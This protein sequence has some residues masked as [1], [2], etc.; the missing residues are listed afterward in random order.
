MKKT[1]SLLLAGVLTF[2][3]LP[4]VNVRAVENSDAQT[5]ADTITQTYG[6]TSVQY[7]LI[8]N[9]EIIESGVSGVYSKYEN[10]LLTNENMYTIGSTSKMF[11]TASIMKLVQEGKIDLDR[12]VVRYVPQFKMKDKRYRDITVR[13]LL[14]H[15]S[16][17]MGST[18]NNGFLVDDNDTQAHDSFL[19]D[20]SQQNLKADPGAYSVY[21]NDSF[22]L[23]EIVVEKVSKM[24]F[25]EYIH[26][27]FIEPLGLT[28]TKTPLD[29]FDRSLI[30]RTYD[31]QN[32]MQET[33]VDT[34]NVIGTGG[35]YSTA[36]DLVRFAQVFMDSSTILNEEVREATFNKEYL[37]G[38]WIEDQ[39]SGVAYG[40]GWDSVN[41]DPFAS[42]GIQAG[43]KGGDTLL[44]HA[45]LIVLPD[46]NMAAAVTSSGGSSTMN[47]FLATQL[48]INRLAEKSFAIKEMKSEPFA[49]NEGVKVEE[50]LKAKAG[51]YGSFAG[52]YDVV[53][54]DTTLSYKNAY[55]PADQ[56]VTM[57]Y[58]GNGYFVDPSGTIRMYFLTQNDKDYLMIEGET[59]YPGLGTLYENTYF[60]QKVEVGALNEEFS[61]AWAARNGKTYVLV[62]SKYTSQNVTSVIP[63]SAVALYGDYLAANKVTADDEATVTVQIPMSMG[64]DLMDYTFK[65]VDGIEYMIANDNIFM[66]IAGMKA[67][68]EDEFKVKIE[69]NSYNQWYAFDTSYEGRKLTIEHPENTGFVVYDVNGLPVNAYAYTHSDETI[70]PAGGYIG[71]MGEANDKFVVTIE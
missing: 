20:L 16:G 13:M 5:M 23:A 26:K 22:T 47:Q 18:Y 15:S 14:N 68:S 44:M 39:P 53:I 27:N 71:F 3:C 48:L 59:T 46:Y 61:E 35:I 17:L 33:G 30:A 34:A 51:D 70:L 40:L 1:L 38:Q 63:M 31:S 56:K 25:T 64:R 43:V 2:S 41:L 4:S 8:D 50:E 19:K 54:D 11:V 6:A 65:T 9:G 28:Y 42:M 21:S 45:S 67:V 24:S 37:R 69:R 62:N 57:L 49:V 7:A 36:E 10:R 66:D 60:A 52:L 29:E 55:A 58:Q 32:P 12:P